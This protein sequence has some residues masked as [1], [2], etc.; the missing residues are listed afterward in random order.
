[1]AQLGGFQILQ[2]MWASDFDAPSVESPTLAPLIIRS[3][4]MTLQDRLKEDD[5][6]PLDWRFSSRSASGSPREYGND[7]ILLAKS[8]F[9][10]LRPGI[11]GKPSRQKSR[12]GS[13]LLQKKG[14]EELSVFCVAAILVLNRGKLLKDVQSM[15]DA[16]KV[17]TG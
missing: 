7:A 12:S 14:D 9:C 15:D 10:G 16:I 8:P 4:S 3:P 2:M 6:S 1:M 13:G 5:H 11:W 17:S